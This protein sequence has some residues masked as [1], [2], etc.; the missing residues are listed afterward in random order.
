LTLIAEAFPLSRKSFFVAIY[1]SLA[2]DCLHNWNAATIARPA[3]GT[4]L[5]LRLKSAPAKAA[6]PVAGLANGVPILWLALT[7]AAGTT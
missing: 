1:A 5:R 3:T 7:V 6:F 4:Q 2:N